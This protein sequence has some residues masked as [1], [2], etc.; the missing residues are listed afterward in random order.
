[1]VVPATD[2]EQVRR[3][4]AASG[5]SALPGS[6]RYKPPPGERAESTDPNFAPLVVIVVVLASGYLANTIFRLWREAHYPGLV[7]VTTGDQVTIKENQAL[8]GGTVVVVGADGNQVLTPPNE[9]EL[10]KILEHTLRP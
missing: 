1:M 5:G 9:T 4:V 2:E 3:I 7:I 10:G 8:P 6:T